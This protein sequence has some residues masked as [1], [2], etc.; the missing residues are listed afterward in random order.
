LDFSMINRTNIVYFES[1][2][3]CGLGLPPIKFLVSVLNYIRCELIHLH[4]NAISVLS[5]FT[6]LCECSLGIP[7]D[8]SLFWYYYSLTHYEHKVFS[9]IG[10]MLRRNHWEE[11]M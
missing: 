6:M 10:L 4:L 2:L 1:H 5:C 8:I 7:P 3:I 11:Y 9:S